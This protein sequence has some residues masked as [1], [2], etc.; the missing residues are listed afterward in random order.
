MTTPRNLALLFTCEHGGNDIPPP[1]AHLFP[2]AR[3]VLSSHRGFDL[4]ILPIA[5]ALARELHAPLITST[6]SR[7]VCDLNRSLHSPTL[8]SEFTRGL[9]ASG[10]N[11]L[12]DLYYHPFR[13]DVVAAIEHILHNGGIVI[14][15]SIH[16]F[17]PVWKGKTRPTHIGLL[18]DPA[19]PREV[20]F[21]RT[22][23]ARLP[24]P[25]PPLPL[26]PQ[27]PLPGPS[28]RPLPPPPSPPPP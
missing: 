21:A 17:T 14:H 3:S 9:S 15:L 11:H 6:V 4:G 28:Q 1:L 7:L 8:F 20:Q 5:T 2:R 13:R 25:P 12:L 26:P 10:R 19:R 22:W 18:Y 24:P 16:S 23:R 27:P